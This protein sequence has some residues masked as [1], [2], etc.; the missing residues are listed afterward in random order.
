MTPRLRFLLNDQEISLGEVGAAD[1]LLDFLRISRRL[2]EAAPSVT[3]WS[4]WALAP[5]RTPSPMTIPTP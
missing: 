3:W 2:T 5:M 1:T 4:S